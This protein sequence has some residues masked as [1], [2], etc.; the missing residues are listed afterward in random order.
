MRSHGVPNFPDPGSNGRG[1][2]EIQQ[3]QRAGSGR[4]LKI[5]G[6]SVSS[7][8]FNSA[9]QSCRSHLPNGGHPPPLSAARKQAMLRFSRCMRAHGITNF[10]DPTFGANGGVRIGFGPASGIDPQSPAFQSAQRACASTTGGGI[11]FK[12]AAP[13]PGG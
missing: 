7:P 2:L 4:S 13:A 10:P 8:A 11:G 1:G 9:M 12:I 3:T 6:V 5:N